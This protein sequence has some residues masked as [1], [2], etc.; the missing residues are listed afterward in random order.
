MHGP[1]NVKSMIHC[2]KTLLPTCNNGNKG[3]NAAVRDIDR[4]LY[5]KTF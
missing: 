4:K 2:Y 1:M 5:G 3:R